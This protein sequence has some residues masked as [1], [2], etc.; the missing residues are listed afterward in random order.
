M[1]KK[2]EKNKPAKSYSIDE[3]NENI[4]DFGDIYYKL[5]FWMK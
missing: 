4:L 1:G 2:S 3:N 5:L